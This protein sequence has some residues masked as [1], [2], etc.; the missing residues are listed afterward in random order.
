MTA[1][2]APNTAHMAPDGEE[3]LDALDAG[4]KWHQGTTAV[5]TLHIHNANDYLL[6]SGL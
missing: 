1:I 6:S 3:P 4:M 5:L 2:I